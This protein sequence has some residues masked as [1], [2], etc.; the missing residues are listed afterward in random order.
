MK[1]RPPLPP[2]PSAAQRMRLPALLSVLGAL[3]VVL[4]T[5]GTP[6][7]TMLRDLWPGGGGAP[8]APARV[9]D[10]AGIL[11]PGVRVKANEY[12][13]RIFDESDVDV[14]LVTLR[15]SDGTSLEEAAPRMMRALDAGAVGGHHRGLLIVYDATTRRGRI[16]VGYGLEEHFPD[17]F[18]GYLLSNHVE[19]LFAAGNPTQGVHLLMRML[20][21]R[22]REAVLDQRFDPR[23]LQLLDRGSHLSGGAGASRVMPIQAKSGPTGQGRVTKAARTRLGPQASPE[24]A[25]K[26][27]LAWLAA[28]TFDPTLELFTP[29]TRTHLASMPMSASYFHFILIHDY[30]QPYEITTRGDRALLVFTKSPLPGPHFF[31]RTDAGWQVDLAAEVANTANVAGGVYSWMYRGE[32]DVYTNRFADKLLK[33]KNYMRFASGDNRMLPL[34]NAHKDPSAPRDEKETA[35]AS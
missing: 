11:P 10:Q 26:A 33:I 24:A 31:A 5:M 20:H 28:G 7:P 32:N 16:E 27:Y 35:D 25:Y 21:H 9:D 17:G 6:V 30:G 8:P 12:A 19:T 22:I 29:Q 15:S 23:V 4:V 14:R 3:L 1:L 13:E 2:P 34:R 18:V